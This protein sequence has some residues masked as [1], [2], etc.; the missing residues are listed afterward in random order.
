[1]SCSR[2]SFILS[3][4]LLTFGLPYIVKE[5]H[6]LETL[7]PTD[8]FECSLSL[9]VCCDKFGCWIAP[10]VKYWFPIGFLEANSDCEFMSSLIPI[11]GSVIQSPLK[12]I[13]KSIPFVTEASLI[14]NYPSA[15]L[16]QDYMRVH[17]RWYSLPKPLQRWVETIL[18]TVH[19]CPCLGLSSIFES[20]LDLP[21]VTEGLEI[22]KRLKRIEEGLENK[23]R[24]SLKPVLSKLREFL[25]SLGGSSKAQ[26]LLERVAE[27]SQ[28]VPVWFTELVS[29]IWMIDILSPDNKFSPLIANAIVNLINSQNPVLGK[30][31]C[32]HLANYLAP[33][34]SKY[35]NIS[36][37]DLSFLCVGYWGR[38]YPRI[39][40]V[41]HDD[42]TIAQLLA[43]A[44]FHHLFSH[45]FPIIR[46]KFTL[47]PSKMKYQIW[48]PVKT[49]CFRIGYWGIPDIG[50][51]KDISNA[52]TL[53]K[54][55]EKIGFGA[56][57]HALTEAI[58]KGRR[59]MFVIVWYKESKCC[60]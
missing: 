37:L 28:Y 35:V 55:I 33:H 24:E 1:M 32:P 53:V 51:L 46:P 31:A 17:A 57:K 52:Q 23:L 41:R 3:L 8:C 20:V 40:V 29:P 4:P 45:T 36:V 43:L 59:R 22:Y 13:C 25:P 34:L 49:D 12:T 50:D 30:L 56:F 7:L 10:K 5:A 58:E 19:L 48:K 16:S 18:T 44:R 38:G 15:Y 47:D 2:R 39:G 21:I 11:V 14:Q 60:C 42:P 9:C 26:R 27:L 6:S 54:R